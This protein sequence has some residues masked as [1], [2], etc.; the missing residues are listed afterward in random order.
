M[1]LTL[2]A[3]NKLIFVNGMAVKSTIVTA[4]YKTRK[5][6][7]F[8]DFTDLIQSR[9]VLSLKSA[10][11]I[12]ND[13]EDRF[14]FSSVT[15]IYSLEQKLSELAQGQQSASEFY[16]K[17]KT[18]WDVIDDVQPLPMC[19]FTASNCTYALTKKI[20]NAQTNSTSAAIS[21]EA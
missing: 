21:N 4:E 6:Q 8:S 5:M 13:L 11:D 19:V 17:I 14:G 12:W 1:M 3:K 16:T 7:W 9:S 18:L 20:H 2:L 10:R 15:Q